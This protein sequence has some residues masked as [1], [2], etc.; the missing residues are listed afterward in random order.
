[1][2]IRQRKPLNVRVQRAAQLVQHLL[3]DGGGQRFLGIGTGGA[4]RRNRQYC[5]RG[6]AENRQ[7]IVSGNRQD[8]F[9]QPS[10]GGARL[11]NGIDDDLQP[12]GLQQLGGA[13]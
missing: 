12:P 9:V 13:A 3:A 11:Q 7:R 4:Q 5:Q 1:V 8:Q 6:H 10:L 2:V